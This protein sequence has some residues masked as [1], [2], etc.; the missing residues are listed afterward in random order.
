MKKTFL[1]ITAIII[2]IIIFLLLKSCE[3]REKTEENLF[4]EEISEEIEETEESIDYKSA[5][6]EANTDFT[7]QI[8]R[9]EIDIKDEEAAKTALNEAYKKQEFPVD[10]DEKLIELLEIYK[11]DENVTAIIKSRVQECK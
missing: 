2:I 3:P 11:T 10:E 7:C 6:I 1:A 9:G 8:I 5:F 4:T